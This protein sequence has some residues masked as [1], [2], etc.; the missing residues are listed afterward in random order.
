[1]SIFLAP[2]IQRQF[3]TVKWARPSTDGIWDSVE[4]AEIAYSLANAW[5]VTVGH[6][7]ITTFGDFE[8]RPVGDWDRILVRLDYEGEFVA[9]IDMDGLY[10]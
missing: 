6:G 4:M 3:G 7:E 5:F 1:M 2:K 10:G 9:L 8:V